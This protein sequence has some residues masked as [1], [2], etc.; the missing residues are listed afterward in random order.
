MIFSILNTLTDRKPS[1]PPSHHP[2][3]LQCHF[4][5]T[6]VSNFKHP[7]ASHV[8]SPSDSHI[9]LSVCRLLHLFKNALCKLEKQYPIH[10][11]GML[12]LSRL[13][14]EQQCQIAHFLF[15]SDRVSFAERLSSSNI[16]QFDIL[17]TDIPSSSGNFQD[18][19]FSC[20][21][22]Q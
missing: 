11:L 1:L 21:P 17:S 8:N 22:L 14:N 15:I 2:L 4:Q 6:D 7:V 9:E 3:N 18:S 10:S 12:R 20:N 13:D 5:G 16:T 19:S